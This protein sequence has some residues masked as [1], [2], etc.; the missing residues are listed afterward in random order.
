MTWTSKYTINTKQWNI[1]K[2]DILN[3]D[4]IKSL[5]KKRRISS[6]YGGNRE[7]NDIKKNER[8]P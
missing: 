1:Y 4:D 6:W 7:I 2:R 3:D 8:I 5:V